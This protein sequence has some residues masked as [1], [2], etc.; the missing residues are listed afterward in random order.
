M[1]PR[2]AIEL[3]PRARAPGVGGVV[4]GAP[5]STEQTVLVAMEWWLAG[6]GVAEGRGIY[7]CSLSLGSRTSGT[8]VGGLG[9]R[10]GRCS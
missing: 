4:D 2:V 3:Q 5:A 1:Q 7:A 6:W 8:A 9:G 10:E